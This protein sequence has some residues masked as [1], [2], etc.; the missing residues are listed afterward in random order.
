MRLETTDR[1]NL[2]FEVYAPRIDRRLQL[3]TVQHRKNF[4]YPAAI[5]AQ[6]EQLPNYLQGKYYQPGTGEVLKTVGSAATIASS[7]F[8]A[9]G[10][11]VEND[12]LASSP[13]EFTDLLSSVLSEP[14]IKA[15]VLSL[16][17]KSNEVGDSQPNSVG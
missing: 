2:V 14:T 17:S 13:T 3:F 12:Q 4:D 11:W 8:T 1:V 7:M 15:S 16:I 9:K 6:K 10:R 5:T